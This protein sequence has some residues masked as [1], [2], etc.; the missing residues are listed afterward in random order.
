MT[1]ITYEQAIVLRCLRR[2]IYAAGRVVNDLVVEISRPPCPHVNEAGEEIDDANCTYCELYEA[3]ASI[4]RQFVE[5]TTTLDNALINGPT[6][7]HAK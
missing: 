2:R 7:Q 6:V 3:A 5:L 1:P 4:E